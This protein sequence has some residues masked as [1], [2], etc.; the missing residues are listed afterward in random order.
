MPASNSSAID[1]ISTTVTRPGASRASRPSSAKDPTP[2]VGALAGNIV[3][4][5]TA[6]GT[7][8]A[9][10]TAAESKAAVGRGRPTGAKNKAPSKPREP[11]APRETAGPSNG[12]GFNT[13]DIVA[14]V[15]AKIRDARKSKT[16]AVAEFKTK[17]RE[18]T[19][20]FNAAAKALEVATSAHEKQVKVFD[21]QIVAGETLLAKLQ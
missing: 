14:S 19:S 5:R 15:N 8:T 20:A 3:L 1:G 12:G 2:S 21:E 7:A 6:I 9:A 10:A 17:N 18:L 16:T 4:P 11:R 13:R